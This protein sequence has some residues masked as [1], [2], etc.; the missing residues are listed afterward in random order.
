M[1][2]IMKVF[3]ALTILS[4]LMISC[5]DKIKSENKIAGKWILKSAMGIISKDGPNTYMVLNDD[6]TA[7][8]KNT[9][10]EH[11]R[12]WS[13]KGNELCLKALEEDGGIESCGSYKIED[14]K[15]VWTIMEIEMIYEK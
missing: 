12:T 13:I 15:L 8:E 11:K 9:F 5:N 14:N 1:K 6:N 7:I 10:G 2:K 3:G 4:M